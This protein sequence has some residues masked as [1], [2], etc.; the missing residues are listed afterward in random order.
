MEDGITTLNIISIWKYGEKGSSML[1][2]LARQT[3]PNRKKIPSGHKIWIPMKN[4]HHIDETLKKI[5]LD[6]DFINKLRFD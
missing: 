6:N 3:L 5:G 4:V 2:Q 1:V